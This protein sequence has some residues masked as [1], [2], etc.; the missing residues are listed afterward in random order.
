MKR[1][2]TK[3]TKTKSKLLSQ[4]NASFIA[5]FDFCSSI[6]M[7]NQRSP[8]V[9]W[10]GGGREGAVD[11]YDVSAVD[12]MLVSFFCLFLFLGKKGESAPFWNEKRD[13]FLKKNEIFMFTT[14]PGCVCHARVDG[15]RRNN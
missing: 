12:R 9:C 8:F 2:K 14:T 7:T 13:V 3:K 6:G 5:N 1:E 10:R 15:A 4:Q 11:T